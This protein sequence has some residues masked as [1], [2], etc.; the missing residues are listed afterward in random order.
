MYTIAHKT[1]VFFVLSSVV[2]PISILSE[3]FRQIFVSSRSDQ[4]VLLEGSKIICDIRL[5]SSLTPILKTRKNSNCCALK[6]E[7][8]N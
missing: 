2:G 8:L 3:K 6:Q 5:I 7:L 4:I 1:V